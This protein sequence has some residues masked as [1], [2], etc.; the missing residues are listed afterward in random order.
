[1]IIFINVNSMIQKL[2]GYIYDEITFYCDRS[3]YAQ[4]DSVL[5][6]EHWNQSN[7]EKI[8]IKIKINK[9]KNTEKTEKTENL[10][11]KIKINENT[12]KNTETNLEKNTEKNTEN[13]LKNQ[14]R[15]L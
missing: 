3:H 1:M 11:I 14:I 6:G 2:P 10:K 13:I 15:F 5:V 9:N 12:E 8:K 7:T 4:K